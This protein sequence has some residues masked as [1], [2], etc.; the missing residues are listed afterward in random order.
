MQKFLLPLCTNFVVN[1]PI[2]LACFGEKKI[3]HVLLYQIWQHFKEET[4]E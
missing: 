2:N 4:Y 3:G 1:K